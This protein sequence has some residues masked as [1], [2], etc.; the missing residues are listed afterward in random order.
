MQT[1]IWPRSSWHRQQGAAATTESRAVGIPEPLQT[2]HA[3]AQQSKGMVEAAEIQGLRDATYLDKAEIHMLRD[4]ANQYD[5]DRHY[6]S[7]QLLAAQT[8]Y[9]RLTGAFNDMSQDLVTA[10]DRNAELEAALTNEA[11]VA[12]SELEAS[13]KRE[14]VLKTRLELLEEALGGAKTA[15]DVAEL[16]KK[17]NAWENKSKRDERALCK[18]KAQNARMKL[19][20]ELSEVKYSGEGGTG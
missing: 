16:L 8:N 17:I 5:N 18:L 15:P 13:K 10:Q 7:E 20:L 3:Q 11:K 1:A 19:E 2:A 14:A 6:Y 4:R 12:K 9:G